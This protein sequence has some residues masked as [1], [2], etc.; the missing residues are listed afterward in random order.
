M[1]IGKYK[2]ENTSRTY[3]SGNTMLKRTNREIQIEQI[4]IGEYKSK[5]IKIGQYKSK[6]YTSEHTNQQIQI[7]NTNQKIQSGRINSEISIWKI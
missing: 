5:N 4:Q 6:P 1:Q 7:V 2:S 3:K